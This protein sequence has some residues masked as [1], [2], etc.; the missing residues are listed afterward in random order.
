MVPNQEQGAP[1]APEG[2]L[3]RHFHCREPGT[4][5]S[6]GHLVATARRL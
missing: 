4:E 2:V 3:E 1:E 6:V 5:G